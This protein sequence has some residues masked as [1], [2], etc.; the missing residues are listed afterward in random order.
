MT[1]VE[2]MAHYP[3]DRYFDE[4]FAQALLNQWIA[5][6]KAFAAGGMTVE[7][8]RERII[9]GIISAADWRGQFRYDWEQ[10]GGDVNDFDFEEAYAKYVAEN[11]GDAMRLVSSSLHTEFRWVPES[12]DT[13]LDTL[14][15]TH[16]LRTQ[17]YHSNYLEDLLPGEWLARFLRLV[18]VSSAEM[19]ETA[20]ANHGAEGAVFVA[21]MLDARLNVDRDSSRPAIMNAAQV[22]AALENAYTHAIPVVHAEINLRALLELDPSKPFTLSTDKSGHVHIGLHCFVNGAGYMDA[23]PGVITI[24]AGETGFSGEDRWSYG[25]DKTYCLYKPA[26]KAT[27]RNVDA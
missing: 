2:C 22:I 10:A 20:T 23:Y 1:E 26:V 12:A 14:M 18:N 19:I 15:E 7:A 6:R 11:R 16:G 13:D 21:R 9:D 25:I 4:S 8:Y 27:P 17:R 5:A 24:P 3:D